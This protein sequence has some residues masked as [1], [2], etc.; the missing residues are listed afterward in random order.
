MLQIPRGT[1]QVDYT[2]HSGAV[3]W[4]SCLPLRAVRLT[5]R[6]IS[7]QHPSHRLTADADYSTDQRR[8]RTLGMG[9]SHGV[10]QVLASLP[11]VAASLLTALR[12]FL[13][14]F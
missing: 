13:S 10:L 3:T 4:E 12:S 9:D 11:E 5:L 6:A 1:S 2:E 7:G 14:F 8:A